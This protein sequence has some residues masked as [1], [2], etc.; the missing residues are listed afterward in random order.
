MLIHTPLQQIFK[1]FIIALIVWGCD[2]NSSNEA[3][4]SPMSAVD[5]DRF[6][7]NDQEPPSSLMDQG[8]STALIDQGVDDPEDATIPFP[9]PDAMMIVD[10]GLL[11]QLPN[12]N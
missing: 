4:M 9:E 11:Q 12:L 2:E 6:G 1:L 10:E 3:D 8:D 5:M 7:Q